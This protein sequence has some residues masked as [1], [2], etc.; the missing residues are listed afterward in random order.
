[1]GPRD[2]FD[3]PDIDSLECHGC[4]RPATDITGLCDRCAS[5]ADP[6]YAPII[7]ALLDQ[8]ICEYARVSPGGLTISSGEE[9]PC[10]LE[11]GDVSIVGTV[12]RDSVTV[13]A[14]ISD[15]DSVIE[16]IVEIVDEFQERR[17]RRADIERANREYR[18]AG[19]FGG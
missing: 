2:I 3:A 18:L 1:M 7:A 13:R 10:R 12:G 11:F 8:D 14:D 6:F 15:R 5:L 17:V 16:G 4:P 19:K 9:P